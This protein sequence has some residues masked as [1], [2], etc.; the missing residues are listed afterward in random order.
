MRIQHMV[1]PGCGGEIKAADL[2]KINYCS[3]CGAPLYIDDEVSRSVNTTIIRDEARLREAENEARRLEIEE[4]RLR[5]ASADTA[6]DLIGGALKGILAAAGIMFLFIVGLLYLLSPIDLLPG[7]I[8][9]DIVIIY[10]CVKAI[11]RIGSGRKYK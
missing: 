11:S 10:L 1:C 4:Q 7:I 8:I 3:Y 2:N 9:D 6:A 5:R